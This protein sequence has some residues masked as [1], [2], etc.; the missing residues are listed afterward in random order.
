MLI[1][2]HGVLSNGNTVNEGVTISG[3]ISP[4]G[5]GEGYS[6]ADRYRVNG[7]PMHKARRRDLPDPSMEPLAYPGESE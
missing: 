1:V 3:E 5:F 6:A 4:T 7:R 2:T